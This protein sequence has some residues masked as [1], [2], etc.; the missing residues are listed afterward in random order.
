MKTVS[1]KRQKLTASDVFT[2]VRVGIEIQ[3]IGKKKVFNGRNFYKIHQKFFEN[4]R[5]S[6]LKQTVSKSAARAKLAPHIFDQLYQRAH[7]IT[8]NLTVLTFGKSPNSRE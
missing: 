2:L 4:Y 3:K 1:I 6:S 7:G 8:E 5:I